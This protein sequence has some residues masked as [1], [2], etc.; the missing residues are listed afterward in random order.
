MYSQI[1]RLDRLRYE[2]KAQTDT[3]AQKH[4]LTERDRST[5]LR[6]AQRAI[7]RDDDPYARRWVFTYRGARFS[8]TLTT[9]RMPVRNARA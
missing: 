7:D 6:A 5:L 4:T 3:M 9:F 2:P 1:Q 8:D